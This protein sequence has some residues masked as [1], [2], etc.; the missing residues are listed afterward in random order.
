M[1]RTTIRFAVWNV[2]GIRSC[3]QKGFDDW[4]KRAQP[5]VCGLQEVRAFPESIADAIEKWHGLGYA[6]HFFPAKKPG[7]SGTAIL[8]RRPPRKVD[9]GVGV[10]EF[11]DEGRFIGADFGEFYFA[12][13]Y[14]PKGSG[15]D[16]SNSRVPFKLAFYDRVLDLLDR[17]AKKQRVI[18][19][20][21][22][23]TAH[24]EI[25]LTNWKTNAKTS[26]FLPEE[27]RAFRA[28][29]DRGFKDE[30]RERH[31]GLGGHYTWWSQRQG[32]R[33]R[34]V[35]WRIDYLLTKGTADGE[36]LKAWI[37]PGQKGS[38]HC[39]LGLDAAF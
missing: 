16:R 14:F 22:F 29:I 13:V 4:L 33:E 6:A 17:R 34:N 7:Y 15:P 30:F 21:D 9:S 8:T 26:G 25:D 37:D 1:Q 19:G 36:I 31:Q 5:D 35:G 32:A 11:D 28:W 3:R 38:D 20:G 10:P 27:R 39:P 18:V 23:N 12:S 2:N 24:E